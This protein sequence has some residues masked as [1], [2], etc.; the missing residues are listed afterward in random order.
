MCSL[1]LMLLSGFLSAWWS[2]AGLGIGVGLL[3]SAAS[4][5]ANRYALRQDQPTFMLIVL[6]GMLVRILAALAVLALIVLVLSVEP[7]PFVASFSAVFLIGLI[8]EVLH[9]H[10]QRSAAADT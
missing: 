3:Y 4:L 8:V 7:I 2:S 10:R 5:L 9:L 6:G 1:L